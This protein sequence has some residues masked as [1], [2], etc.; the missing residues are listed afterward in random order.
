MKSPCYENKWLQTQ[1]FFK[2]LVPS[3]QGPW[4]SSEVRVASPPPSQEAK[5]RHRL[6]L[7]MQCLIA[8]C[9]H[10]ELLMDFLAR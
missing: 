2:P 6:L 4:V 5:L 1:A 3:I 8:A 9:F 7:K 10:F